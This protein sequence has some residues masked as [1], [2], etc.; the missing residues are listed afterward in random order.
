MTIITALPT[1]PSRSDPTFFAARADSFL[2]AL[3]VF[4]TETNAVASEVNANANSAIAAYNNS[5]ASLGGVTKWV[6]GTTYSDGQI[7]WS[8]SNY[9]TYR[10]KGAGAGTTDPSADTVNYSQLSVN[11]STMLS[12]SAS[13]DEVLRLNSTGSPYVS[14]YNGATRRFY[15]FAQSTGVDLTTE[16]AVPL[17]FKTN[18]VER[19][20]IDSTGNVSIGT[21]AG[22]QAASVRLVDFTYPS[23][24]MD[25]AGQGFTAFNLREES[26]SVWKYKTTDTGQVCRTTSGGWS[27][28]TAPSGA[29]GTTASLVEKMRLD[30]NGN[31]GMNG[32]A[33]SNIR[34]YSNAANNTSFSLGIGSSSQTSTIYRFGIN[35]SNN[36]VISDS[37]SGNA[38]FVVN[39]NGGV[40]VGVLTFP[41]LTGAYAIDVGAGGSIDSRGAVNFE[42]GTNFYMDSGASWKYKTTGAATQFTQDS[43]IHKWLVASSG[44]ANTLITWTEAGRIANNGTFLIG[45][46]IDNTA[47]LQ[48]DGGSGRASM[49]ITSGGASNH[50]TYLWNSAIA[51]DNQFM[52]FGTE[53]SPVTR[54]SISYNRAGGLIAYNTTS[55]YRAK[56]ILGPVEKSGET[57][58]KLKVYTGKMKDAD[59]ERPMLI[60]HEIQEVLPYAVTGE[61]D[62]VKEDGTPLY[63]QVDHSAMIPLLI[64]EIQ[65]LRARLAALEAK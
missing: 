4:A 20:R 54:G 60:A 12:L 2:A 29:A 17:M 22:I 56:T 26:S 47:K 7:V 38:Q 24:G 30:S 46:T 40:G 45:T 23:F 64:A 62:A 42:N 55:D 9:M 59:L 16:L 58:D 25:S 57:I 65:S 18:N 33:P 32:A 13:T 37:T 21:V 52:H 41:W 19:M 1:P 61:K 50:C 49:F 36:L 6:S 35:S 51:G 63:Q 8:P 15:I 48:V 3:P 28:L 11:A 39:T 34:L 53:A 44:T 27:W 14:W 10:R 31:I 5:V 43:G